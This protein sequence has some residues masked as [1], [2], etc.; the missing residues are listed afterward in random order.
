MFLYVAVALA[1][2][3]HEMSCMDKVCLC[4]SSTTG[5][6]AGA[7]SESHYGQDSSIWY[8]PKIRGPQYRPQNTIILNIG[9][10]KKVH[11][12]P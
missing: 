12:K 5:V 4:G 3:K 11:S 9:T 2:P 8:F 6:T 10:P 1:V 7:L